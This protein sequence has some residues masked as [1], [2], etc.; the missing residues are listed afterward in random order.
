MA[1]GPVV[2]IIVHGYDFALQRTPIFLRTALAACSVPMTLNVLGDSDGLRGFQ[3][4]Y[5]VHVFES[6]LFERADTLNLLTVTSITAMRRIPAFLRTLHPLCHARGYG[7]LFLKVLAAELMPDADRLIILDP[8]A[9]VLGDLAELWRE[10]DHFASEHIV[11]MAVDQSDRYYYRLQNPLDEAFSPGWRGVPHGIG[12]NGGVL[13]LHAARAR[14]VGFANAISALT[15]IGAAER[16]AGKLAAFCDLAEQDT[17][18]LAIARRPRV[19]R[20]LHIRWNYMATALG[21]HA[22]VPD[23]GAGGPLTLYDVCERGVFGSRSA[24]GDLLRSACGRK[25][26]ILHYVGGT[27]SNSLF[28][29]INASVLTSSGD[30]LRQMAR[31]RAARPIVPSVRSDSEIKGRAPD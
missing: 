6:G 10:F 24:P 17:L 26:G 27:R 5:R 21:G 25:V 8:D 30:M 1:D 7:F 14:S 12:V 9:I 20:P 28:A 19:W 18:N 22:M 13:L 15:H 31:V 29:R 16:A 3:E 11:S 4:V 23:E 2:L